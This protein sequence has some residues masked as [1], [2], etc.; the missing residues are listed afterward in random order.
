MTLSSMIPAGRLGPADMNAVRFAFFV[1]VKMLEEAEGTAA[2]AKYW[3]DRS[4]G[5]AEE[6]EL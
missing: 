1:P 3:M 2:E 4:P 6:R 5:A